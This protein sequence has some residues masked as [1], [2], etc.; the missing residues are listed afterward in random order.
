MNVDLGEQKK[1]LIEGLLEDVHKVSDGIKH[2]IH[3]GD[4]KIRTI[5]QAKQ[6]SKVVR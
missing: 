5:E 3:E 2:I 6:L 1:I 4:E